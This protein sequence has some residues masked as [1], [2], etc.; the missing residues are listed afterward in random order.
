MNITNNFYEIALKSHIGE[1][2]E[3]QDAI[4]SYVEADK[5]IL[6]LCDGMGGFEGGSVASNLAVN[7]FIN[8]YQRENA[9]IDVDFLSY[10]MDV[11]DS[12]IA[13][14][15]NENNEKIHAGTT[16]VVAC[17]NQRNLRWLSVGDSRL[18]IIRDGKITQMTRDH[19]VELQARIEYSKGKITYDEFEIAMKDKNTLCSYL[20]LNGIDIFDVNEQ[21]LMLKQNDIIV[22]ATDGLFKSLTQ[23]DILYE[24]TRSVSIEQAVDNLLLRAEVI[25]K[26]KNQ[27]NTSVI[28]CKIR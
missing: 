19:T 9:E 5:G 1:R 2:A 15:R 18:Y 4:D 26:G 17:L 25:A 22:M 10:A 12:K 14:L 27:D 28:V 8:M 13:S 3:Q 20:G 23:D 24:V 16:C 7:E 21:L 6:V 11:I